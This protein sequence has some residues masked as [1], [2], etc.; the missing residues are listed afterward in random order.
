[1]F[2]Y[3]TISKKINELNGNR[4]E[5]GYFL[6]SDDELDLLM[7]LDTYNRECLGHALCLDFKTNVKS[8]G[9][10]G[11]D[12]WAYKLEIDGIPCRFEIDRDVEEE[13]V[14]P[15]CYDMLGVATRLDTNEIYKMYL[16]HN[17]DVS[18]VGCYYIDLD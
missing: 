7:D 10:S 14:R 16:V 13:T 17:I 12:M 4:N 5:N 1:M 9:N 18:C 2:C 6:G 11:K 8:L 3:N 15:F